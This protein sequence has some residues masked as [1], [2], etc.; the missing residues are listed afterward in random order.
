MLSQRLTQRLTQRSPD[1]HHPPQFNAGWVR[2]KRDP[3]ALPENLAV[4]DLRVLVKQMEQTDVFD[5]RIFTFVSSEEAY[6][7]ARTL[8]ADAK[9]ASEGA[10]G[11]S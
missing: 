5:W 4:M 9:A 1:R 8:I 11:E 10:G 2:A 3:D 7:V 6:N